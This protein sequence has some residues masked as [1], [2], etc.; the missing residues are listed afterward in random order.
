MHACVFVLY[1]LAAFLYKDIQMCK[2]DTRTLDVCIL[3]QAYKYVH[4]HTYI[5]YI[6][7]LWTLVEGVDTACL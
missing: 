1:T 6:L 2:Y 5:L 3:E 4:T 7:L